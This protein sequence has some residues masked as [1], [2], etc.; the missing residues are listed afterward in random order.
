MLQIRL[1]K[2]RHCGHAANSYAAIMDDSSLAWASYKKR[3]RS[4][5]INSD[6]HV[7]TAMTN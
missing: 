7:A 6:R 5:W 4:R 3:D 1:L 2:T